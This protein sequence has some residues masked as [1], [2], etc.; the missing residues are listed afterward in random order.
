MLY[1]VLPGREG[2]N[3]LKFAKMDCLKFKQIKH[4]NLFYLPPSGSEPDLLSA[5]FQQLLKF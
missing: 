1:G 5:L 4:M 2:V 3:L